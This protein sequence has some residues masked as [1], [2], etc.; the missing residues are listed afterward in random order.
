MIVSVLNF[1]AGDNGNYI[2]V[3][4]FEGDVLLLVDKLDLD[5]SCK[6]IDLGD[7]TVAVGSLDY[8]INGR[9]FADLLLVGVV[10][11]TQATHKT[12]ASAGDFV[13][14]EGEILLL[15]HLYRHLSKVGKEARAAQRAA[16]SAE[17][18]QQLCFVAY[19]YL[20]QLDSCAEYRC[21]ILYQLSE[22]YSACRGEVEQQLGVV[23]GIL[24]L[25]Q[26]H[27]KLMLGYLF[28]TYYQRLFFPLTVDL[29]ALGVGVGSHA[30]DLAQR[31]NYALF[32]HTAVCHPDLAVFGTA[33][34][35]NYNE[36]TFFGCCAVGIEIIYLAG[37][38]ETYAHY[39][40]CCGI[41]CQRVG[42]SGLVFKVKVRHVGVSNLNTK[43]V[44]VGS[45]GV[46]LVYENDLGRDVRGGVVDRRILHGSANR[47]FG[48]G[49]FVDLLTVISDVALLVVALTLLIVVP[50]VIFLIVVVLGLIVSR[51][52]LGGGGYLLG[53]LTEIVLLSLLLLGGV[54]LW[55]AVAVISVTS[56][57]MRA[58]LV[59]GL[60]IVI[61]FDH[62]FRSYI[63]LIV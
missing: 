10:F 29:V 41:V 35:V 1:G 25:Y 56:S 55:L 24:S 52:G 2:A 54:I 13:G 48:G 18:A 11:V 19:S 44:Y 31:L 6:G 12:S 37:T 20:T 26:L 9:S 28:L 36:S 23:K 30:Q 22:V 57:V 3:I 59:S 53:R 62:S 50:I 5:H 38:A 32:G 51:R 61:H 60:V 33:S 7:S 16:A 8:R 39:F 27:F 46:G 21:Q 63:K 45:G 49:I 58:L 42:I 40:Y 4:G 34:G 47:R 43:I 15:C 14:V 17:T